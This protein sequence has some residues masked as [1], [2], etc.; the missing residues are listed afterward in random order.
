MNLKRNEGITLV[1]LMIT[2]IILIILAAVTIISINKSDMFQKTINGSESYSREQDRE[3][4][5]AEIEA[6]RMQIIEDTLTAS[7]G[8]E[9]VKVSYVQMPSMIKTKLEAKEDY[10]V[11]EL[12]DKTTHTEIS[13]TTNHG[14]VFTIKVYTTNG[15]CEI[16]NAK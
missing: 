6:I 10:K 7:D 14:L 15:N 11:G 13:V 8:T 16:E 9:N 2:V 4:I 1:A 5:R 12:Q 3:Y